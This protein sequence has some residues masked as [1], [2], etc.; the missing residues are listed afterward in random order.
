MILRAF[1]E[2][3]DRSLEQTFGLNHAFSVSAL[4]APTFAAAAVSRDLDY[5]LPMGSQLLGVTQFTFSAQWV[6]PVAT[7]RELE[8]RYSVRVLRWESQRGTSISR[9][10]S[11]AQRKLVPGDTVAV[12]GSLDHLYTLR[13]QTSA[14]S[15]VARPG[16]TIVVPAGSPTTR[17]LQCPN[18]QYDT[19]IVCGLGKVG[20]RVVNWLIQA[21]PRP[22]IVVIHQDDA[23]SP[24]VRR[25]ADLD[26][27]IVI[28]GDARDADIL[29]QAGLQRSYSIAALTSDDLINLQIGL[30]ARRH[31]P[32]VHVVLRVFSDALAEKLADLFG[33]H[34]T[35]ST[36]DLAAPTLAAAA[37]LGGVSTAFFTD[38]ALYAIDHLVVKG[39]DRLT[40]RTIATLAAQHD[41]LVISLTRKGSSQVLPLYDTVIASDDEL[42]ILARLD[43]LARLRGM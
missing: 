10:A 12:L 30:E 7:L 43:V 17:P 13:M 24:F 32:D 29:H 25:L 31:R 14:I 6:P 8:D 39:R 36:S 20:F 16:A 40:G 27:V 11:L 42:T 22:R 38:G 35:Y 15:P 5:V 28:N 18:V 34:T 26:G 41:V 9:I 37:V 3:F 2:D 23:R 19:V 1:S 21:Q 4:G 33:I